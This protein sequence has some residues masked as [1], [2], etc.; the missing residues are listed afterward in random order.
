MNGTDILLSANRRLTG[1]LV[2]NNGPKSLQNR[3][4][5]AVQ[6][7]LYHSVVAMAN[8]N[9]KSSWVISWRQ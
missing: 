8:H 5:V 4:D 2:G 3:K 7:L 6:Q 1:L 9:S